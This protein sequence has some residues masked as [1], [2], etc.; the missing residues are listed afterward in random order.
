MMLKKKTPER[1]IE[2]AV[3]TGARLADEPHCTSLLGRLKRIDAQGVPGVI[4]SGPPSTPSHG[5][6][7]Y[8]AC[9]AYSP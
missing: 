6:L 2:A 7:G 9:A 8:A 5:P 3:A 4:A 1:P